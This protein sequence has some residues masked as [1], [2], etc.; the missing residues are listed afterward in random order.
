MISKDAVPSIFWNI[1]IF[2]DG[3]K[4]ILLH[5]HSTFVSASPS[6]LAT[7]LIVSPSSTSI[8]EGSLVVINGNPDSI[9]K[10][11]EKI[12]KELEC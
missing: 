11:I 8:F 12:H 6:N 5:I 7:N 10:S 1:K 2:S 3:F 9:K 4:G